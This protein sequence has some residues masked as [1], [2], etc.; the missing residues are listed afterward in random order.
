MNLEANFGK[1][2]GEI[3]IERGFTSFF[4]GFSRAG[5]RERKPQLRCGFVTTPRSSVLQGDG[6]FTHRNIRHR[7]RLRRSLTLM[8]PATR[9]D[10]T[11]KA[12]G[13]RQTRSKIAFSFTG[14][15]GRMS[16]CFRKGIG[17][18]KFHIGE[19]EIFEIFSARRR[20]A[21]VCNFLVGSFICCWKAGEL[22]S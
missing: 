20:R 12:D 13:D 14:R 19:I 11:W 5:T 7:L 10:T 2:D 8:F 16:C 22:L 9:V 18:L 4:R 1:F 17:K 6:E 15:W 3:V 21:K